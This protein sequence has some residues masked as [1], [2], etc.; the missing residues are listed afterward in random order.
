MEPVPGNRDDELIFLFGF[1]T[2]A[3]GVVS[4]NSTEKE[5]RIVLGCGA[6]LNFV[7]LICAAHAG[8]WGLE[9]N[10]W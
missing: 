1:L 8:L 5:T 3:L 9:P 4:Y 7:A 10:P 2:L 6:A